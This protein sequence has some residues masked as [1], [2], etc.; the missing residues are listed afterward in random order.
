MDTEYAK[1]VR[2]IHFSI[3]LQDGSRQK[4]KVPDTLTNW[5]FAWYIYEVDRPIVVKENE[6]G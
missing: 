1:P 2:A 3:A 4:W 6:D 5:Q